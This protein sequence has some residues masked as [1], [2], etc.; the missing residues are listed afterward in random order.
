MNDLNYEI[1]ELKERFIRHSK[2][3]EYGKQKFVK[4]IADLKR[5]IRPFVT[6]KTAGNLLN[7]DITAIFTPKT[8]T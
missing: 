5:G 3:G 4:A 2:S 6:P 1:Q 8:G 7:S